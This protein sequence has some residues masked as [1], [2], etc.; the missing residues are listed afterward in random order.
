MLSLGGSPPCCNSWPAWGP[1][2]PTLETLHEHPFWEG[3]SEVMNVQEPCREQRAC[4]AQGK[5]QMLLLIKNSNQR[6]VS[7]N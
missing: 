5:E 1:V 6:P 2:C 4:Q 7:F 3:R